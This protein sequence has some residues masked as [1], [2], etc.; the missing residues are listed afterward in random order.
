MTKNKARP[1]L[2]SMHAFAWWESFSF[3]FVSSIETCVLS[4]VLAIH[5]DE[6]MKRSVCNEKMFCKEEDEE[7]TCGH[8]A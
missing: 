2:A 4:L 1:N 3:H 7:K 6:A 5:K 8:T